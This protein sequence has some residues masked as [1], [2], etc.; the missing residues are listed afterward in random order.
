LVYRKQNRGK[1]RVRCHKKK[2]NQEED[3]K[4]KRKD[5]LLQKY[6]S[7]AWTGHIKGATK[8]GHTTLNKKNTKKSHQK[9]RIQLTSSVGGNQIHSGQGG[10]KMKQKLLD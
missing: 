3:W 7:A 8:R 5:N 10:K 9:I 6:V 2:K 1:A 4:E